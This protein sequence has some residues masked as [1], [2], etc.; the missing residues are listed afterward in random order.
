MDEDGPAGEQL[1]RMWTPEEIAEWI[2]VTSHTVRR[3]CRHGD[4]P[5]VRVGG[6]W[7][8]PANRIEDLLATVHRG[9]VRK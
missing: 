8:V 9:P 1:P 2:G 6:L 3:W 7:R 4:L 5:G